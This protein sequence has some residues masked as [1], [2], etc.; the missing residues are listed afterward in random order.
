MAIIKNNLKRDDKD[1]KIIFMISLKKGNLNRYSIITKTLFEIM[2]DKKII[3]K[4]R[5]SDNF[6]EFLINLKELDL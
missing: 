1:I 5:S 3:N 2:N 6:E 4:L